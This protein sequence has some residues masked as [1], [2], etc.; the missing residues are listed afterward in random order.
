[1]RAL[2]YLR[3]AV[4]NLLSGPRADQELD[5][6]LQAHLELLAEE[7]RAAGLDAADARRQA[8]LETGGVEA[9]KERVRDAR[10]GSAVAGFL[11]DVAL[12][13]R[14]LRRAPGLLVVVTLTLALGIGAN[15][16]I[17]SAAW[18][19]LV[20]P[21]PY[22]RPDGLFM[23]WSDLH[24]AGYP[25]APLSGPELFDLREGAAGFEEVA[26]TWTTTG[27]LTG[28]GQ[29]EQ[30][31]LGLVTA[32]F[33][34]T[35]GVKPALGRDFL[36][37]EEGSE[38][39]V[40]LLSHSLW[41]RR[42][43][44]DPGVIGKTVRMDGG[45]AT[46]VGV[47]PGAFEPVFAEDANVSPDVQAWSPFVDELR[48]RPRGLYFLRVVGRARPG[49][50]PAQAAGEVEALSARVVPRHPEY[51]GS[52]RRFYAVPLRDD[53]S[54][55]LRPALITL[56]LGV[57]I[58]LLLACVN[59]ATVLLARGLARRK[60]TA[61]RVALGAS[62]GRLWRECLAEGL[63]LAALGGA[64]GVLLGAL[65]IEALRS[66][67]PEGL[68]R[69]SAA[70]LDTPVLLFALGVSLAAG[71]V[72]SIAP[73]REALRTEPREALASGG[74][75]VMAVRHRT[76]GGLV[77]AQVTLGAV[78][79]VAAGLLI[80]SFQ[81][82]GAVPPGY[83]PD[84]VLTFRLSLPFPR[85]PTATA[86]NAFG[87]ELE[88]RLQTLPGVE[89]V[90]AVSHVP[91]D[92]LPNWSTPYVYEA[93]AGQPR[94]SHEADARAVSPGYFEAVGAEIVRGRGFLEADDEHSRPVVV[95]DE[96]LAARAW[97]GRDAVG[98][99]LEVE[100]M[101]DGD[102]VP[103][104]ATVAGVV[105]HLRHRSLTE[106]VRE[107]VYVPY[108]QSRRDP[109]A[110]VVRTRCDPGAFAAAVR[111]EVAALDKDLPAYDVRRLDTYVSAWLGPRRFVMLLSGLFAAV[112]LL[113]AAVGTYGVLAWA[114]NRRQHEFGVRR[115]LGAGT[116]EVLALVF[117][118]ALGLAAVGLILGLATA[119]VLAP[120]LSS[121]LY[122][123]GPL[124]PLT[125]GAV[126]V[127]V[128]GATVCAC[129]VPARRAAALDPLRAL[130]LL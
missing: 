96:R 72:F 107:Q 64:A 66:L 81:A 116:A 60:E 101:K 95:V 85:Y 127:V 97:P 73:L 25:R 126:A 2:A 71:L 86:A 93:I 19:V 65:G 44:A 92:S 77:V 118:E 48:R 63:V 50:S 42:Y 56:L 94:G 122:G 39:R 78:L 128:I 7:K 38:S 98:Q 49:T 14:S 108:R 23:L 21:L 109:M 106:E 111:A 45:S 55:E 16:A 35:L 104:K 91:L 36:P 105:R 52:G 100:F 113:I 1:M 74:R 6:E 3:S 27:Q 102:F 46:I 29:P 62:P 99:S 54:G 117:G 79:L 34:R 75:G 22:P 61:I 11:R 26:A 123:I 12:A 57:L 130:R 24:E 20:E 18:A 115:A 129:V 5:A 70:R 83:R 4:L 33:L 87:R 59:V 88:R 40:L 103:T 51:A 31:R 82:A 80:R 13:G 8:V 28:D 110:Y 84:N 53:V 120:A 47:M 43:G 112:A 32:N 76:R 68:A 9:V 17:F 30:I 41:Q 90:G 114:V 58:L 124:D 67:R 119:A 10:A 15:T 121:Q 69:V 125:Y 37:G 89:A